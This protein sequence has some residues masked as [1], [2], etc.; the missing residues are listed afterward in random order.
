MLPTE[1]WPQPNSPESPLQ[2]EVVEGTMDVEHMMKGVSWLTLG[3]CWHDFGQLTY[4]GLFI[5]W[6]HVIII[7]ALYT[8]QW[9]FEVQIK[10]EAGS[11]A[12]DMKRRNRKDWKLCDNG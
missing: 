4:L 1:Q 2:P 6:K 10:W 12:P 9:Y 8:T 5:I 3:D 7:S 11:P